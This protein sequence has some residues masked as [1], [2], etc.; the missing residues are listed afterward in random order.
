MALTQLYGSKPNIGSGKEDQGNQGLALTT[1]YHRSK[2]LPRVSTLLVTNALSWRQGDVLAGKEAD[3]LEGTVRALELNALTK[4]G[5]PLGLEAVNQANMLTRIWLAQGQD[6]NLNKVARNDRTE[7]QT[8][9]DG[10][11]LV[12]G[13][14]SGPN[15]RGLKEELKRELISLDSRSILARPRCIR[16][17]EVLSL[18]LDEG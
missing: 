7:Y 10:T 2:K 13:R 6:E 18:D 4:E 11:I 9:K 5:E 1:Q 12:N 15:D 16:T 3:D 14:I 17:Q 8:A